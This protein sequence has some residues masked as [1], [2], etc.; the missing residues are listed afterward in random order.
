LPTPKKI[1]QVLAGAEMPELAPCRYEHGDR[2]YQTRVVEAPWQ[3]VNAP[4]SLNNHG[5][6]IGDDRIDKSEEESR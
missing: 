3:F 4:E 2:P 5:L 6:D 1:E